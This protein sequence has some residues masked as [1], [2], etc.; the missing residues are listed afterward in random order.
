MMVDRELFDALGGFEES[1]RSGFEDFDFCQR[2]IREG[3]VPIYT[4]SPTVTSHQ[5]PRAARARFDVIDRALFVDLHYDELREG[6]RFYNRG[7]KRDRASFEP[8]PRG[9][10]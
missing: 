3:R 2:A 1:Y 5:A 7:F 8:A 4:P 6:D 9:A 10:A